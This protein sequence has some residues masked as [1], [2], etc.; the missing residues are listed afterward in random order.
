[1]FSRIFQLFKIARKLSTSGAVDTIDQ[2]YNLPMSI[3]IFFSIIS[4]GSERKILNN[5]KQPGEK[6]CEALEGMGTTFIK[7]GQFLA[8]RPDII[9]EEL[10][11]N[12]EKL[13]DKLPA[14]NTY[15]AKKIIKKEIGE[16]QFKNIYEISEPIAAASIAQVHIAKI[17]Y[18]NENKEVAIKI[19]RPDIEKLFNEELDALMLFAYLVENIFS[20]AKRLKL[21]EVVHLLREITNIE[22]DLRFEA[23]AANE[24]YENTKNDSGFVV[25]K[26]YWN[27][28][29]KKVL[30]LDKVNGISI[31]EHEK[32]KDVGVDLK[33]LAEKLI[34]HFLK[35][36]IRDGF[37]HGDMHQGNLFVDKNGNIIPVDFG[38]MGRLDK[39]NRKFL[40]EILYGF[41]QRDYVKVAEVH[42]QAGLVPQNASKEE[43]AQA[44]RSV[45]EPIFGQSI[46]DISG[47]NLLAQLFEITEKFNMQTQTPLLLLQKTM[48]VVEGVARRLYPDTNIWEV[49]RPVLEDWLKDVKSPKSTFDTAINTSTEIIKRIPDFPGLMDRANYALQLMA[50]GKLNLGIRNNKNIELEEMKLK[51][52]R[53]NLIIGFFGIVIVILLV[54]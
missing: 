8:T 13:Q 30:T 2:I 12:L 34:Q 29:T 49:S 54:F 47:G 42:F 22:M 11:K 7:L 46:K 50:E 45:G 5:K 25:P 32:L 36:A 37:F 6:L 10:S 31:R 33:N 1:M 18:E 35:Q 20:K 53:N 40:A 19:L 52:F 48:V 39:N 14:F 16:N 9:G 15:E 24:L 43:F 26:I 51:S 17:N 28:T 21:V 23:A 27:Y 38:I 44:L 41:I 3:K 4:V